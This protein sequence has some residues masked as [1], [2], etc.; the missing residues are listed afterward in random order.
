MVPR[1]AE[2]LVKRREMMSAWARVS[3]GSSGAPVT[4]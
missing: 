4:T 3:H 2:D 1:T